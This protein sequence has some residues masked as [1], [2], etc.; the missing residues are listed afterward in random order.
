MAMTNGARTGRTTSRPSR[1]SASVQ[2]SSGCES[3]RCRM[4]SS[5]GSR[6]TAGG[7]RRAHSAA[8]STQHTA[9]NGRWRETGVAGW[10]E[11]CRELSRAA[12]YRR[13]IRAIA[14]V[15]RRRR[16]L[17]QSNIRPRCA[18]C[19]GRGAL[20]LGSGGGRVNPVSLRDFPFSRFARSPHSQPA[21]IN[22]DGQPAPATSSCW[23]PRSV[24]SACA[25]RG[26]EESP[27]CCWC[28]WCCCIAS[29]CCPAAMSCHDDDA[30]AIAIALIPFHYII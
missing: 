10:P 16:A 6:W 7:G 19:A 17:P 12:G 5:G 25:V 22:R 24:G 9:G 20:P 27:G 15:K 30:V 29:R 8:H 23:L 26:T 28:C 21:V 14:D 4:M 1:E 13:A 18:Q 11:S 2:A 3:W